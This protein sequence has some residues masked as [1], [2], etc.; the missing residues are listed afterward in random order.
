MNGFEKSTCRVDHSIGVSHSSARV[1][2][3]SSSS[4]EKLGSDKFR[5]GGGGS[6]ALAWTV[7]NMSSKTT[8]NC[9]LILLVRR[10]R[11]RAT[12][13]VCNGKHPCIVLVLTEGPP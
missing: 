11:T 9:G 5:P 7:P 13:L 6:E 3:K 4:L 2:K 1:G 8:W 10:I 12:V